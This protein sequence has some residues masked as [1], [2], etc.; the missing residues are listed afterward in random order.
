MPPKTRITKGMIIH[1][2][3]E[4]VKQSGYENINA[5]TVSEQLHCSTQPVMYHFATME[6]LKR[7]VYSRTDRYHTEY[8]MR[9]SGKFDPLLEI[10]LNYIRFAIREPHLFRFLFQSGYAKENDL[11]E[12]IDSE[13]LVPVLSAMQEGIRL[14]REKTKEIFLTIALFVHGYA[15]I[16]ANN[17]LEYDE[18]LIASHLERAFIG[19]LLAVGQEEDYEKTV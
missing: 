7:A 13:E 10:G 16:I 18:D 5:R 4:V 12:M 15:S 9:A 2:A 8:L 14:E 11:L 1:A 6:D 19:A 17:K 3:L